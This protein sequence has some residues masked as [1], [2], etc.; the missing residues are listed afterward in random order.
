MRMSTIE[1]L[2]KIAEG[3]WLHLEEIS[4]TDAHGIPRKWESVG[5]KNSCG[6]VMMITKLLPSGD[7]ILVR[8]FRPPVGRPVIEFPAGLIE[9]G[10]D[11]AE[12]AIRELREETGYQG[13]VKECSCKAY[14][15]PGLS[16]EY[17][18]QVL[19]TVDEFAQGEL[20]TDFDETEFIETFRVHPSHLDA[21]LRSQEEAGNAV[22]AKV[23]AF[24]AAIPFF[25]IIS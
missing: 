16:S 25:K 20:K 6:A 11:P 19:V 4:Y 7:L 1:S 3:N 24:A 18:L 9:N 15:S 22:D 8:Q 12:A 14:N 21:F 17:I 5:R 23:Q 2:K 10:E 13:I